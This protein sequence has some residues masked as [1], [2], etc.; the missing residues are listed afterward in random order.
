MSAQT[1]K[2]ELVADVSV[3]IPVYNGEKYIE[4]CLSSLLSQTLQPKEI[5]VIN[6]GSTD[7][8]IDIV[9]AI[10]KKTE[11]IKAITV[12][13]NG[14][15]KARNIGFDM[16][17]ANYV[18]FLDADDIIRPETIELAFNTI[19]KDKSDFVI[20]DWVFYN[21]DSLEY[22]DAG[23]AVLSVKEILEGDECLLPLNKSPYFSVNK[24][25]SKNFLKKNNIR[26]GEWRI[27]EDVPFWV[28]AC[29][30]AKRISVIHEPLYIV[31]LNSDS[32]TKTRYNTNL[33]SNGY[34]MAV[35]ESLRALGE[36]NKKQYTYVYSYFLSKF[37][38]Y[39]SK[40]TSKEHKRDFLIGFV[41]LMGEKL[42]QNKGAVKGSLV[43]E[44]CLKLKVFEK[45]KYTLMIIIC[46][47]VT[48]YRK[49]IKRI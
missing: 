3:I 44:L 22:K 48:I 36:N 26:Y 2:T 5:I 41:D 28:K 38:S 19:N 6:D 46:K 18:M 4:D 10:I 33:H 7:S 35:D 42:P 20:F 21:Y 25:Y 32:T 16:C 43:Y 14:Q 37:I 13:N 34:L 29:V 23:E 8:T 39:Y 12:E 11:N 27:Y 17:L 24:I 49:I 9:S 31:R 40:R 45:K 47:L 30:A 1:E 15:G